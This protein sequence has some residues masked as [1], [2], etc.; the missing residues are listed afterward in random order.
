[1]IIVWGSGKPT[2]IHIQF[3]YN[4]LTESDIFRRFLFPSTQPN[5]MFDNYF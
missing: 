4:L 5:Y 2:C 3:S 1:M